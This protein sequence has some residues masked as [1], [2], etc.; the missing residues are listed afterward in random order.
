MKKFRIFVDMKKEEQYLNQMAAQGWGMVKYN[1]FSVY[2]FEKITPETRNYRI[3]Y[4][5]FNKRADYYAY[6][7]LFEDSGWKHAGGSRYSGMQ[8]FL[9]ANEQNQELDIFSDAESSKERY[10]RLYEQA[11]LWGL[12][13]IIYFVLFQ[14]GVLGSI[15]SW[16]LTPDL[17]SSYSGMQLVGIVIIQTFFAALRVLP[18]VVFFG[19]A[20]YNLVVAH[21]VKK[22]MN[23]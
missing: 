19:C 17:W 12:L 10:K 23:E 18:F 4:H 14:T 3:D 8:F 20:I 16:Y 21:K 7:T 9:P 5:E 11:S 6:L 2:T 1:M 13:M 15:N 22:L